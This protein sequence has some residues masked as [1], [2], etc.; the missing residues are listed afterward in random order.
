MFLFCLWYRRRK[1]ILP[2]AAGIAVYVLAA[3]VLTAACVC[4]YRD[5][6]KGMVEK[7]FSGPSGELLSAHSFLKIIRFEPS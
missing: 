4:L 2:Q 5:L 1:N 3:A 7:I 6:R